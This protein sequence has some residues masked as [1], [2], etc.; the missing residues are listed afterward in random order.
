MFWAI[1]FDITIVLMAIAVI[2]I[3][4]TLILEFKQ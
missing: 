2:G 3:L 1:I 4:A